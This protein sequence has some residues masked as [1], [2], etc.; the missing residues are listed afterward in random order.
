MELMA[1][2]QKMEEESTHELEFEPF[3]PIY[4]P[5]ESD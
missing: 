3:V 4:A 5:F 1:H 2:Q